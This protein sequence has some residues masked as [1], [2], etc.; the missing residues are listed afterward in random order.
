MKDITRPKYITTISDGNYVFWPLHTM[1][2]VTN[3]LEE[4][5]IYYVTK[6]DNP[7]FVP[8][9]QPNEDFWSLKATCIKTIGKLKMKINGEK[10][11]VLV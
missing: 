1:P 4:K 9:I 2:E 6:V 8:E 11:S 10:E 7:A 5:N 3:H